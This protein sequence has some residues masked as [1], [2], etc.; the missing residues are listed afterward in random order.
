[1]FSR[2]QESPEVVY[3]TLIGSLPLRVLQYIWHSE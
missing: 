3:V 2:V 1:M